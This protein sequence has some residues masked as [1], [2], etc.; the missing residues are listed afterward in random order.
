[1]FG[2]SSWTS[3][4]FLGASHSRLK[5]RQKVYSGK[6]CEMSCC[7]TSGTGG[8]WAGDIGRGRMVGAEA[9]GRR[10]GL[11]EGWQQ[12]NNIIITDQNIMHFNNILYKNFMTQHWEIHNLFWCYLKKKKKKKS[13]CSLETV[14]FSMLQSQIFLTRRLEG[15]FNFHRTTLLLFF[16]SKSRKLLRG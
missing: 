13:K 12:E 10:T 3:V 16:C 9:W 2:L 7:L 5:N 1:M 15:S 14:S 8:G 6:R 11:H 4:C